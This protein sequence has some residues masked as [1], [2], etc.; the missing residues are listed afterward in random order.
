MAFRAAV[1]RETD[2]IVVTPGVGDRPLVVSSLLNSPEL[3]QLGF[4]FR[5]FAFAAAQRVAI[6]CF[7]QRDAAVLTG[8]LLTVVPGALASSIRTLLSGS[9][10]TASC[11]VRMC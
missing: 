3:A 7:Q 4:Q 2:K 5:G 11:V 8:F 9:T 10:R 1:A 6:A